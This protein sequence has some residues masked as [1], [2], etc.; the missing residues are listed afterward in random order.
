MAGEYLRTGSAADDFVA[1]AAHETAH[2][3]FVLLFVDGRADHDVDVHSLADADGGDSGVVAGLLF[4]DFVAGCCQDAS[5]GAGGH[6]VV[7][8]VGEVFFDDIARPSEIEDTADACVD[9]AVAHDHDDVAFDEMELGLEDGLA[10]D[11]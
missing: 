6:G 11:L 4:V 10:A 8:M 9:G 7:E 2:V 5:G 1:V 3:L